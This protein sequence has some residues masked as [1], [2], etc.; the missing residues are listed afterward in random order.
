MSSLNGKTRFSSGVGA[1]YYKLVECLGFIG[2]QEFGLFRSRNLVWLELRELFG[3]MQADARESRFGDL[4]II[5]ED[6]GLEASQQRRVQLVMAA[7]N[8][9]L[10]VCPSQLC[11]VTVY[12]N[13]RV[14]GFASAVF[15]GVALGYQG[16]VG[17]RDI[18]SDVIDNL[19]LSTPL[20]QAVINHPVGTGVQ[21]ASGISAWGDEIQ[22][23]IS[24]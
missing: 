17:I 11:L 2:E 3:H 1:A 10:F 7:L 14:L 16:R 24:F 9:R 4:L 13:Q 19:R 6:E 21:F 23:Y 8:Q 22:K 18:P 12:E 20:M 15:A 5:H